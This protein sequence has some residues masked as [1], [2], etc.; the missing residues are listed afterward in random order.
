M[1]VR[2]Y[3]GKSDVR[4][5]PA[6][7]K[8]GT[9]SMVNFLS[10]CFGMKSVGTV[11]PESSLTSVHASARGFDIYAWDFEKNDWA[12]KNFEERN[13]NLIHYLYTNRDYLGIEEIHDYC[14]IYVWGT[15]VQYDGSGRGSN[16]NYG[17]GY[18]CS[19]DNVQEAYAP[20]GWKRWNLEAHKS[21]GGDSVGLKHIHVEISPASA[22]NK[23]QLESKLSLSINR[24]FRN[25]WHSVALL[26]SGSGAYALGTRINKPTPI[27]TGKIK[28]II[29]RL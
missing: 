11:N 8:P 29:K 16:A 15:M 3:T 1:A 10:Y 28:G 17:A 7:K 27:G 23:T 14:G 19:R 21:H 13:W 2:P 9:E 18:R 22:N 26:G 20:T 24:Y 4:G 5:K 25:N 12:S 6:N